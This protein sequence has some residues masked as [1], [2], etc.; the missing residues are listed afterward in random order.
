M[1]SFLIELCN[2]LLDKLDLEDIEPLTIQR[3]KHNA[4]L[5]IIWIFFY[6]FPD[7]KMREII[8]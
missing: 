5:D 6:D 1:Y 4:A 7:Y 3:N 8:K 2:V